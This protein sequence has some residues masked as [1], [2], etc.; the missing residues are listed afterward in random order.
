MEDNEEINKK[1]RKKSKIRHY[2]ENFTHIEILYG[3]TDKKKAVVDD[4]FE[5]YSLMISVALVAFFSLSLNGFQEEDEESLDD[6]D[7]LSKNYKKWMPEKDL[8][9]FRF[10][11]KINY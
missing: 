10:R 11:Q 1:S 5:M 2:Y 4:P 7:D 6:M 9:A 3:S 8:I